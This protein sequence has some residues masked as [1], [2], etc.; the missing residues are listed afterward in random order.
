[1][2]HKKIAFLIQ[3]LKSFVLASSCASPHYF[4]AAFFIQ[5]SAVK[6]QQHEVTC[7][8]ENECVR[9][10]SQKKMQIWDWQAAKT[11]FS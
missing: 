8:A 10:P 6:K 1:M 5:D 11:C 3:L 7:L 4:H 2:V 9:V